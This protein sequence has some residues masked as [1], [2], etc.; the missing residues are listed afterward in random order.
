MIGGKRV[1]VVM[2]AYN[3][4]RTLEQTVAELDRT[5][6][7]RRHP[8]GRRQ[9][10]RDR[11]AGAPSSA[12]TRRPPAEPRLRRQPEDLLHR[13]AGP[14]R[15]HRGH[16][17]PGLPVLAEAA[18]RPWPAWWR[19]ATSTACSA[20]ASSGWAPARAACRSGST[21]PT[22]SS[23]FFENLLLGYKLSE[24][25]TGYRAFSRK[26]L[27]TL[28]LEENSDDFVF[29][30]QMLAQIL[31][32]GFD[33]GEVTCPTRYFAEASSINFRR[34]VKYGF[35]VLG[36]ALEYRLARLGLGGPRF[37]ESGRRL[38]GTAARAVARLPE[39]RSA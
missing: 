23:R 35:G 38:S 20:R 21:W 8:G 14:R 18:R 37:S 28:P 24:Y 2:P 33:I 39:E 27:E 9:P 11:Q 17:P 30:N 15:R 36:T 19:A 16:G 3:A 1:C 31:W 26:L 34:S 6:R 5:R 7:R 13:G 22:G 4:A 10:R 25:H 32:F 12:S 29:D